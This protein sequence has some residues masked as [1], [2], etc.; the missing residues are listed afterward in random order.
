MK[1]NFCYKYYKLKTNHVE[2]IIELSYDNTLSNGTYGAKTNLLFR[3][4]ED[5]LGHA[6]GVGKTELDAI[7]MCLKETNEYS[8]ST[9]GFNLNKLKEPLNVTIDSLQQINMPCCISFM[10]SKNK[11]ATVYFKKEENELI[12]LTDKTKFSLPMEGDVIETLENN[13]KKIKHS[14]AN[15]FTKEYLQ[16]NDFYPVFNSL[17]M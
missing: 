10:L 13:I 15:N 6:A 17:I 14:N 3:D 11:T 16:Q 12:V 7:H 4:E 5:D 9:S 2:I 1:Y 8:K